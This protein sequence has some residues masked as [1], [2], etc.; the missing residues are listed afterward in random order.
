MKLP[1]CI[2]SIPFLLVSA[3]QG[4]TVSSIADLRT[5]SGQSNTTVTLSP[6]T[7]WMGK[8]GTNP[9]FLE[10]SGNNTLYDMTGCTVYI[11]T[12]D[13]GGLGSDVF[14]LVTLSGS[15]STL[16]GLTLETIVVDGGAGVQNWG[17]VGGSSIRLSGINNTVRE[18]TITVRGSNPYGYGDSLGKGGG[19]IMP[20]I[21][22]HSGIQVWEASNATI[23]NCNLYMRSFG[24]GIFVQKSSDT[25]V[26]G[27]YVQGE[28]FATN[29]IRA[30][31][32]WQSATRYRVGSDLVNA[33]SGISN[34]G[35]LAFGSDLYG[36][37][38]VPDLW[39]LDGSSYVRVYN[40]A[41][42]ALVDSWTI[43][44]VALASDIVFGSDGRVYISDSS[45]NQ[46]HSFLPDGTDERWNGVGI[47]KDGMQYP[48]QIH[49]AAN[50]KWY[51]ANRMAGNQSVYPAI[52]VYN[53]DM[54]VFEGVFVQVQNADFAGVTTIPGSTDIITF[55]RSN[56][57]L[58]RWDSN[59]NI[60]WQTTL[61]GTDY[62]N[63]EM[64][65]D[66]MLYLGGSTRDSVVSVDPDTGFAIGYSGLD[67]SVDR[68]NDMVFGPDV[69]SDGVADLYVTTGTTQ[70]VSVW[71]SGTFIA[72]YG[73]ELVADSYLSGS[74][75]GVR[76]YGIIDGV[77]VTNLLVKGCVV[78]RMRGAYLLASADGSTVITDCDAYENEIGFSPASNGEVY[79][80]RGDAAIGP[81]F[82][83]QYESDTDITAQIDL[84]GTTPYNPVNPVALIRGSGHGVFLSRSLSWD[85]DNT[86]GNAEV[87]VGEPWTSDWRH[88][89]TGA[90]SDA[91]N[92]YLDSFLA[93]PVK[94]GQWSAGIV[95]R[96]DGSINNQ[97]ASNSL[98]SGSHLYNVALEGT[99]TQ[100][101]DRYNPPL[102]AA[103]AI[104]GNIDGDIAN[105]SITHTN[106]DAQAWWK[107]DLGAEFPIEEIQIH[108]RTDGVMA[109]LSNYDVNV[110]GSGNNLV[111]TNYQS[112][113]PDP[114]VY[115]DANGVVGRHVEVKL[116]G[117]NYLHIGEVVV[118]S[119]KGVS[120]W[121]AIL[122]D[123][124]ENG[125]GNW[126]D[127]G[128]DCYPYSGTY[129]PSGN[130][131]VRLRDNTS[132]SV[133]STADLALASYS[134]IQ[135]EFDYRCVSMD[136]SNEDFWLQIST[137]GGSSYT[138]VEEWNLNDEFVND[139]DYFDETVLL[140]GF[141]LTNQTR[142][143]FRCDA[144]ANGDQVYIDNVTILAK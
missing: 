31:V 4:I 119:N 140:S 38:G 136:N 58:T 74:E 88:N 95:G 132:T 73:R 133:M 10:L 15:G 121:S 7:Y 92:I 20:G 64:G 110:Y 85:P 14:N 55:D 2:Y 106:A 77:P 113:H 138:T 94:L 107:V 115:L 75:D 51:V 23:L 49:Q 112:A 97:G 16:K 118:L 43:P 134:D 61:S 142:V 89:E 102:I 32:P 103:Y 24:H 83:V 36:S 8:N 109:R 35:G 9:A 47:S 129:S 96:T 101:S 45:R 46:V 28:L 25:T 104:D 27:T 82:Y 71:D 52:T 90:Y 34:A 100:S 144:S 53:S 111:W 42:G 98:V 54:T 76:A 56:D 66:G 72:V 60:V 67:P 126:T 108:N 19:N 91:T 105:G 124:F 135:V 13:L 40:G 48:R 12:E 21:S 69:D 122:D 6:G 62:Y 125:M 1:H 3:L 33:G 99:A 11:D 22:K 139:V 37:D 93:Q 116:R 68:V 30:Y 143:R 141:A 131:S 59:A 120:S 39:V 117:T 137:D 87:F 63:I 130:G 78:E 18:T 57:W 26:E 80:C 84:A 128:G 44:N 123:D 127:G 17:D 79:G 81:I 114:A 29:D 86:Y 41:S 65:P 5:N 50:G 70:T